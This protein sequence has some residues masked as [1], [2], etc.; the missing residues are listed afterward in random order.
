MND[1]KHFSQVIQ[2]DHVKVKRLA[3]H[4]GSCYFAC[5]L[6]NYMRYSIYFKSVE[7]KTGD[8][9]LY[10]KDLSSKHALIAMSKA[11]YLGPFKLCFLQCKM[12]CNSSYGV[13]IQDIQIL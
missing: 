11:K 3:S 8:G 9:L 5:E 12:Y 4:T 1:C 13:C 10:F 2:S 7:V 6:V